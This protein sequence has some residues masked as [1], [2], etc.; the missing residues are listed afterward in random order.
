MT[1]ES[2][3]KLENKKLAKQ[4]QLSHTLAQY[5]VLWSFHNSLRQQESILRQLKTGYTVFLKLKNAYQ[6]VELLL[7]LQLS[8]HIMYDIISITSCVNIVI[9][10][11]YTNIRHKLFI[12]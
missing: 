5:C 12:I 8:M 7:N 10:L 6:V 4:L 11:H 2:I 3:N 1:I 9:P